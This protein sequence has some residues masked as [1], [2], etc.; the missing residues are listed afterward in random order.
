VR[1]EEPVE[2]NGLVLLDLD[3]T[4]LHML[5]KVISPRRW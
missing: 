3:G 4:L 5:P 2:W 1:A